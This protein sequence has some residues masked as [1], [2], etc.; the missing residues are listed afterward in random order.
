MQLI[1]DVPV[2]CVHFQFLVF[3]FIKIFNKKKVKKCRYKQKEFLLHCSL[4]ATMCFVQ[5]VGGWTT[6]SGRR[7]IKVVVGGTPG[8]SLSLSLYRVPR[9]DGAI[10]EVN[11]K[12]GGFLLVRQV[13]HS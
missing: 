10:V 2:L 7:K 5:E 6:C 11:D 8:K 13:L 12:V 1:S 4:F 9:G 3:F